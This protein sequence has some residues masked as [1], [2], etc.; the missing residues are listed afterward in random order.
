M[1]QLLGG[2][3]ASARGNI[4]AGHASAANTVF[5]TC[6]RYYDVLKI[7]GADIRSRSTPRL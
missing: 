2:K 6:T 5:E 1:H 4:I 3:G 7:S